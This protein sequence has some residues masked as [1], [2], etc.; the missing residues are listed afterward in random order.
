L[1]R[2]PAVNDTV[3]V[4]LSAV[5]F[6]DSIETEERPVYDC[7]DTNVMIRLTPNPMH[8]PTPTTIPRLV[9]QRRPLPK[10]SSRRRAE[11]FL[12]EASTSRRDRAS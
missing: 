10:P 1:I 6:D 9:G 5:A 3:P 12:E 7:D 4:R 11:S 2:R 8:T